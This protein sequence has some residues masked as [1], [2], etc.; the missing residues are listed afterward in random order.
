MLRLNDANEIVIN[1]IRK[2]VS[3]FDDGS[4]ITCHESF[5][6]NSLPSQAVVKNFSL[7]DIPNDILKLTVLEKELVCQRLLLKKEL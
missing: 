3:R 7:I 2:Y 1:F 5:K 6:K 4:Y